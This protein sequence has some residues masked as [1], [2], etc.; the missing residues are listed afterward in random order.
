MSCTEVA[1]TRL[2][3]AFS[4]TELEKNPIY[5]KCLATVLSQ[6]GCLSVTWDVLAEDATMLVWLVGNVTEH[7]EVLEEH[8]KQFSLP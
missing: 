3:R 5:K 4:K 7:I 6:P 1:L 8:T 2:P